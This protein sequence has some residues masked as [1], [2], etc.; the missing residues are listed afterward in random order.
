LIE[1]SMLEELSELERRARQLEPSEEAFDRWMGQLSEF[2]GRF[3]TGLE[4]QPASVEGEVGPLR[5]GFPE[6]GEKLSDALAF[7][8]SHVLSTGF[9]AASGKFMGYIPGG[10]IPTAAPGL[11]AYTPA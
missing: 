7:L 5:R 2:A 4:K 9:N 3:L 11:A 8:E 1:Q 10:G 6:H